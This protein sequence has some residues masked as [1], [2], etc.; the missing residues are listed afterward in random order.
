MNYGVN[1]ELWGGSAWSQTL[2]TR[3]K[4]SAQ[5]P[6]DL[7]RAQREDALPHEL[8]EGELVGFSPSS[9]AIDFEAQSD[10]ELIA[11]F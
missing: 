8:K 3:G 4:L 10:T 9:A 5:K 1:C 11:G 7:R 6:G 2:H